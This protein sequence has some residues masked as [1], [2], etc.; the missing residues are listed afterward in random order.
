MKKML[1]VQNAQV[2]PRKPDRKSEK[3][4]FYDDVSRD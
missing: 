3:Q 2:A 4:S 1:Y